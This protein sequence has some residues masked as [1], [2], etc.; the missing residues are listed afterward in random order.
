[1]ALVA[2]G[3]AYDD[4]KDEVNGLEGRVALIEEQVKLL[5][6]NVEVMNYILDPQNKTINSVRTTG[7]GA[8]RQHIIT[9]SDGTELVLT[10]GRPGTIAEPEI[11]VGEDGCWYIN[12]E[13]T[14]VR[15]VGTDGKNGEGYPEFRVE[16]GKWEVRFGADSEWK[17]VQGG[18]LAEGTGSL[19]D[20]VFE[21]AAVEGDNF[22]V[23][24]KDGTMYTLPIVTGLECAIAT[25][26]LALDADGYLLFEK[27][28]RQAVDVK[29]SGENPQVTYPQGW[30]AVLVAKEVA[31]ANGNTH[32]L[33]IYASASD[34]VDTRAAA[35]NQEDIAVSVQKGMFW[36]VD[37]IRVKVEVPAEPEPDTK[38]NMEKYRDGEE[39]TVGGFTFSNR[40]FGSTTVTEVLGQRVDV[41]NAGIYFV[42]V[43]GAELTYA[44][45]GD[46]D[47]LVII[48]NT[49]DVKTITLNVNS[50]IALTGTFVCQNVIFKNTVNDYAL[51]AENENLNLIFDNCKIN[52][53]TAGFGLMKKGNAASVSVANF[54]VGKSDMRIEEKNS[55]NLL[56]DINKVQN[57]TV[58]NSII[59]YSGTDGDAQS[60]RILNV[61]DQFEIAQL[62]LTQNTFVDVISCSDKSFGAL[63][64]GVE[65]TS[66][67]SGTITSASI[68]S[69]LFSIGTLSNAMYLVTSLGA[70]YSDD[71]FVM[72][73]NCWFAKIEAKGAFSILYRGNNSL[74]ANKPAISPSDIFNRSDAT[75]F[76]KENGI[77]ILLD[78]YKSYG[79]TRPSNSQN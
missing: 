57:L 48:P 63:I 38:N 46:I 60:F 20:Q 25:D 64:Y 5:N 23:T 68:S 66:K 59:Y 7:S 56:S 39:L 34:A 33:Y 37:K 6:A 32:T 11:T 58:D 36:A 3:C 31:D 21:S 41:S 15:A 8:N 69:N 28:T 12:G 10:V 78:A 54:Y 71:K 65:N 45:T 70:Q 43:D 67:V 62:N 16:G 24:L 79:A 13:S 72:G 51:A 52:G 2:V 42:S 4:L 75:T 14:G 18:S 61:T 73:T 50:Q 40:T 9:L 1:M 30:R 35:N 76:D 74:A 77:F 22:V 47:N 49:A 27:D 53:L 26:A 17:A 55:M 29:I 44:G 19:G